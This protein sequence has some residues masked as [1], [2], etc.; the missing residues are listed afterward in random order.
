MK[1][2]S[3]SEKIPK[4]K[5][6][7]KGMKRKQ[8]EVKNEQSPKDEMKREP[9]HGPVMMKAKK[10]VQYFLSPQEAIQKSKKLFM[11]LVKSLGHLAEK[12]DLEKEFHTL[13]TSCHHPFFYPPSSSP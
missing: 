13:M 12:D 4:E 6:L 9:S 5:K 1:R 3:S 8:T 11:G 10:K 2:E 7:A